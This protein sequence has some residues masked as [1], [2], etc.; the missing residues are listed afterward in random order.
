MKKTVILIFCFIFVLSFAACNKESNDKIG[1][2][3]E[4]SKISTNASGKITSIF[5]EGK[6]EQDTGHDKA[7]ISVKENIKIYE[8]DG[9]K[10]VEASSLK[11]G[12]RV[13]VVFE[14]PVRESYPVQADAKTIRIIK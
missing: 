11:E 5:V 3:G 6:I 2:R 14:G 4:I 12:M 8:A 1:I 7:S 9:K 10:K 13:E